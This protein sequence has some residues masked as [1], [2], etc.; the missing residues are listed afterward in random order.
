MATAYPHALRDARTPCYVV[1]VAKVRSNVAAM[2]RR[3]AALGCALRPHLKTHKTIEAGDIATG[4]TKRRV[5]VSTLSEAEF[6]ADAG[7]PEPVEGLTESYAPHSY[8][9]NSAH[10]GAHKNMTKND[11]IN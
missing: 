10:F 1:D 9:F 11:K 8:E 5:V 4:G 2:Q 3:A 7:N 6:F